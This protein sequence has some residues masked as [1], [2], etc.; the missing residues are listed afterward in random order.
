MEWAFYYCILVVTNM[1]LHT[2]TCLF[3]KNT[4]E[5]CRTKLSPAS[6]ETASLPL[7]INELLDSKRLFGH[8]LERH[9]NSMLLY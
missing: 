9:A 4:N 8:Q 7:H 3:L 1:A 2:N 5:M 6:E